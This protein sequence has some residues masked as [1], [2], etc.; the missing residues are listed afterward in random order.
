MGAKLREDIRMST[1]DITPQAIGAFV[2]LLVTNALVL[3]N[4]NVTDSKK[5]AIEGIV[6][7]VAVVGFLV[8]DFVIRGNRAKVVAAQATG[9]TN[10]V[11][12]QPALTDKTPGTDVPTV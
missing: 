2:I 8:H 11:N 9:T 7:G 3:F 5:A 10:V 6:N 4:F 1:P 12:N